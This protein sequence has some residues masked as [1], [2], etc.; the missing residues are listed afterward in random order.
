M[1]TSSKM[2]GRV[3]GILSLVP[4]IITNYNPSFGNVF[5]LYCFPK[6]F[7]ADK[8]YL[9]LRGS[10]TAYTM[11]MVINPSYPYFYFVPL[12]E[13]SVDDK[14]LP[15]GGNPF[16]IDPA[17]GR[18]D[19]ILDSGST[20]THLLH[21][22]IYILLR[23]AVRNAMSR[24]GYLFFSAASPKLEMCF[25]LSSSDLSHVRGLPSVKLHFKDGVT[26]SLYSETTCSYPTRPPPIFAS[27]FMHSQNQP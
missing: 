23:D 10:N 14:L 8:D 21:A 27:P 9:K 3:A 17:T 24:A 19:I 18:G 16:D 2:L 15:L 22:A 25:H 13:I 6:H 5:C 26:I 11:P 12:E 1:K 4:S 20:F 7:N